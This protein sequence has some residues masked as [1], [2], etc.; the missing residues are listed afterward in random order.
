MTGDDPLSY[1]ASLAF[2]DMRQLHE[3]V[4]CRAKVKAMKEGTS[5]I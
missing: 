5:D 3:M 2:K 1:N 4:Q